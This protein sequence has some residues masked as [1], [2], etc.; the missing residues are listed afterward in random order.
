MTRFF[1]ASK[2]LGFAALGA[3]QLLTFAGCANAGSATVAIPDL[4][5]IAR[6]EIRGEAELLLSQGAPRLSVETDEAEQVSVVR[7]GDVLLIEVDNVDESPRFTLSLPALS[8][9]DL[10][11]S[12]RVRSA[13]LKVPELHVHSSG[14]ARVELRGLEV[15]RLV[16]D[17]AG[18]AGYVVGGQV[19][20][21]RVEVSGAAD[22]DARALRA[23]DVSV[24]SS[25]AARVR[26]HAIDHL[27]LDG[28]GAGLVEYI[29]TPQIER[30]LSGAFAVRQID[31]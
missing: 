14:S 15:E 13:A 27:V 26:V 3:T 11:G 9:L 12:A 17:S 25:G 5:G 29:G 7:E 6:V 28:S 16:V 20:E 1:Y 21:M 19:R 4:E 30:S 2:L 24:E 23:D 10:A 22:Y 18:A 31:G 8:A